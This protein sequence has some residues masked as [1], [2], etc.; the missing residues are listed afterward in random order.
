MDNQIPKSVLIIVAHPDDETL[1]AGGTI[2]NNP[3]WDFFVVSL[4]RK[5]DEDRAPKF[6]KVLQVLNTK[7]IMGNLDDGPEQTPINN[8]EIQ[9][10]ILDLL[11]KTDFDL[12][13]THNLMGEYT[14]HLRHE[15]VSKAV[16]RLWLEDKITAD[17]L[18]TFAYEDGN[19]AYLPEA[20]KEA[21]IYNVLSES[22]WLKK[23]NLMTK[24]YGFKKNSWEARTTPKTEAFWVFHK[25]VQ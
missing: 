9:Q 16:M 15:E 23:Y 24:T 22:I 6:Y 18:W 25:A 14:R 7:G 17:A 19:K 5:D 12:I 10:I 3:S 2:L 4:C 20:V 8:D 1:W 11:P 21:P 13:I